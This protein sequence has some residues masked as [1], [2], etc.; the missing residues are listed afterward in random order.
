MIHNCFPSREA[1]LSSG[2]DRSSGRT[3]GSKCLGGRYDDV[4]EVLAEDAATLEDEGAEEGDCERLPDELPD[5]LPELEPDSLEEVD[6]DA[7][8]LQSCRESGERQ[9]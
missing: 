2:A 1:S 5:E 4:C 3:A 9:E 8:V 6:G 7:I